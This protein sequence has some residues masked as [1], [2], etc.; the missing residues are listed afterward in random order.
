M[1]GCHP[2][3]VRIGKGAVRVFFDFT[4]GSYTT[5]DE[6]GHE[7]ESVDAVRAELVRVLPEVL[8]GRPHDG[9][10]CEVT[11]DVRDE[12]GSVLFRGSVRLRVQEMANS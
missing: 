5:H 1:I 4:D 12:C 2:P 10:E 3:L 11:C 8:L 9:V 6:D 7:C